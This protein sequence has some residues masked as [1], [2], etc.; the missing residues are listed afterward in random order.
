MK[1][2]SDRHLH[3]NLLCHFNGRLALH[4]WQTIV[5]ALSKV[6]VAFL[7]ADGEQ[8][9]CLTVA[10]GQRSLPQGDCL[11]ALVFVAL[12]DFEMA[13]LVTQW[14]SDGSAWAFDGIK[15]TNVI[16]DLDIRA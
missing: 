9:E 13:E 12:L 4:K 15:V 6:G 2:F 5:S 10:R 11:S 14:E 8:C 1:G 3:N 7:A 16:Y